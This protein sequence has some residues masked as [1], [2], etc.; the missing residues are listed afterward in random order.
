MS[1]PIITLAEV[2]DALQAV[3]SCETKVETFCN[4]V[5][6]LGFEKA[7]KQTVNSAWK[8]A[9]MQATTSKWCSCDVVVPLKRIKERLREDA[10]DLSYNVLSESQ[11]KRKYTAK[12]VAALMKKLLAEKKK[13]SAA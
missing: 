11:F 7:Y 2:K 12:R 9:C 13:E 1:N 6:K 3:H 4:R 8:G 10:S 5:K